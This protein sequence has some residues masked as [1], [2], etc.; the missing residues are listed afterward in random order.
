[1]ALVALVKKFMES[2]G[3]EGSV[4]VGRHAFSTNG[5]VEGMWE[6]KESGV[7]ESED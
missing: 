3:V 5:N 4:E 7:V 1:M 2:V 6:E